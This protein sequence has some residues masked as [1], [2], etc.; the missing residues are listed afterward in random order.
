MDGI[1]GGKGRVAGNAKDDTSG[2]LGSALMESTTPGDEKNKEEAKRTDKK[3]APPPPAD[4]SNAGVP[5]GAPRMPYSGADRDYAPRGQSVAPPMTKSAQEAQQDGF[6]A[7]MAAYRARS[8]VEATRQFDIAARTG[9]QNA[10]LWAAK[11]VKDGNG[12]CTAAIPRFD[13]VTQKAGGTWVGNEA[14]L[15]AARCQIATG[16]LDAAR[17]RLAKLANVPSHAAPAQQ[18]LNELNQV[19]SKR[20]AERTRGGAGGGRPAAPAPVRAP[21]KPAATAGKPTDD[22]NKAGF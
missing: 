21:A 20:E 10:A 4:I 19:A 16:Q 1:T 3:S 8:F 7:G 9:D 15:E 11:S 18:A 12:G 14:Q 22:A 13:A 2:M 5:G 17:E 6:S